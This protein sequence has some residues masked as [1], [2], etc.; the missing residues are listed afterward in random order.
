M[1]LNEPEQAAEK[2][3]QC[4]EMEFHDREEIV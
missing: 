3:K 1:T 2:W 4:E